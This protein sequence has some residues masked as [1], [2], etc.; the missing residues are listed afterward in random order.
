MKKSISKIITLLTVFG[1][2]QAG[3]LGIGNTNAYFVDEEVSQG[4]N[5]SAGIL[6]LSLRSGQGN[7]VPPEIANDMDPGESVARDIYIKK[8]GSLPFQYDARSEPISGS[9][10]P[11][12]YNLLELKVWYNWYD[13]IGKH[14][15]LKYDGL[16]KD[17]DLITDTDLQI[18]NSHSYYPNVFYGPDEHWFYFRVTYPSEAPKLTGKQCE[19]KFVFKGWQTNLIDSS[20][21]FYDT[22]EIYST[23]IDSIFEEPIINNSNIVI[24]EFLPISGNYPEF[25]EFYN[26]GDVQLDIT[27]WIIENK[28]TSIVINSDI[29]YGDAVSTII[30][31]GKWLVI[32][33]SKVGE[34]ILDNTNDIITLYDSENNEIDMISYV[35]ASIVDKSYARIPDGSPNWVD[36]IPT[37]G[38][39]NKLDEE[40]VE[41]LQLEEIIEEIPL[42]TA[43][44]TTSTILDIN[45]L[46]NSTSTSTTIPEEITTITTEPLVAGAVTI[47]TTTTTTTISGPP[48][49]ESDLTT[50][51]TTQSLIEEITTTT[52]T[53]PEETITT[54][55][56]TEPS[57]EEDFMTTTTTIEP[58]ITTTTTTTIPEQITTTTTVPEITTTTTTE[59]LIEE[60]PTTTTTTTTTQP[61]V[62][63]DS[64]P[65][66]LTAVNLINI[67]FV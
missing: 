37:P 31:F 46:E 45:I 64:E 7:F 10:D 5:Y 44:T 51:T 63:T 30:E 3:I 23:L 48:V 34:D 39:P 36:P 15:D 43:T 26:K 56:T 8:E 58:P 66:D 6:D 57:V 4:N 19:F 62:P 47:T 13:D 38:A 24:N 52:T 65:D 21:G 50:A 25:I 40:K 35:E 53:I 42:I 16:L 18:P 29:L 67:C 41:E 28:D 12:F 59:P 27:D 54:T 60:S 1:F 61:S 22:E 14:M 2:I 49:E 20:S 17:F 55:T 32:D 11:E 9:C 33:L